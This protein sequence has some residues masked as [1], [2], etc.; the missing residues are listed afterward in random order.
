MPVPVARLSA[1]ARPAAG[2]AEVAVCQTQYLAAL[3]PAVAP[4]Q[5]TC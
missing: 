1:I 2:V 3:D 4:S 5:H